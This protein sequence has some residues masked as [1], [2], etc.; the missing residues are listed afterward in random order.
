MLN[1][2]TTFYVLIKL[3]QNKV[4]DIVFAT[5]IEML[6]LLLRFWKEV[7]IVVGKRLVAEKVIHTT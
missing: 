2:G 6:I 7:Q 5:K 3:W 4:Q 1:K